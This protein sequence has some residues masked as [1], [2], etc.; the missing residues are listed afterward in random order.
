M[1]KQK[2]VY[3]ILD[4]DNVHTH[5]AL[6]KLASAPHSKSEAA[7]N[8]IA[9]REYKQTLDKLRQMDAEQLEK[10]AKQSPGVVT[11]LIDLDALKR[12]VRTLEK[13]VRQR[14]EELQRVRWLIARKASNQMVVDLCPLVTAEEIRKIRFELG[15]PVLKGRLKMPPMAMRLRILKSWQ[16]TEPEKNLY[17]RYQLLAD[18]YPDLNLGQLYTVITDTKYFGE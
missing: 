16:T 6:S 3:R 12:Q 18:E 7:Y 4:V 11:Y 10:L 8:A 13:N 17:L 1:N 15:V 5:L 9:L 14:S 2:L